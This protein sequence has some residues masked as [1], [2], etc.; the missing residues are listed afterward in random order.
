MLAPWTIFNLGRFQRPVLLSNGF[1]AAVAEADCQPAYYGPD[2]GYGELSC[3]Y[4]FYEGDQ[5]VTE[6]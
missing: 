2:I 4:P 5:S 6:R 1:G 3:L